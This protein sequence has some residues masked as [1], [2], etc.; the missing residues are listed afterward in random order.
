MKLSN[1]YAISST[2]IVASTMLSLS[3]CVVHDREVVHDNGSA[4]YAAG[5]KEGYYDSANHRY[6]HDKAWVDCTDSDIHCR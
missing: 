2:L 3:G 6:W 1:W 5:C 4:A